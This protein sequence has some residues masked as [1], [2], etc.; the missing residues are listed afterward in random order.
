MQA[1]EPNGFWSIQ[2]AAEYLEVS[3]RTMERWIASGQLP[4]VKFGRRLVRIPYAAL[5]VFI[6]QNA[7][8]SVQESVAWESSTCAAQELAQVIRFRPRRPATVR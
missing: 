8:R 3:S 4:T 1:E 5:R 6:A 7:R 2:K